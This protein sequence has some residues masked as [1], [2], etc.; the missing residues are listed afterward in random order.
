MFSLPQ[1]DDLRAFGGPPCTAPLL[2]LV[3]RCSARSVLLEA[4]LGDHE[5]WAALTPPL[6]PGAAWASGRASP[7]YL[8]RIATVRVV[9]LDGTVL[10]HRPVW[11]EGGVL[12]VGDGP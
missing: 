3:N 8:P 7:L 11:G 6:E 2:D 9:G 10:L 12:E 4:R 5:G 1:R